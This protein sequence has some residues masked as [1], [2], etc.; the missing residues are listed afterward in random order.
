[1]QKCSTLF[2]TKRLSITIV[3]GDSWKL[4]QAFPFS[5]TE[6]GSDGS[7]DEAESEPEP[8]PACEYKRAQDKSGYLALDETSR[9]LKN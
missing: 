7:S 5:T 2:Q 3:S 6:S 9:I 8:E 4:A 1:M